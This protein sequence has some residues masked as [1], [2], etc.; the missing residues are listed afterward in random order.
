MHMFSAIDWRISSYRVYST[1]GNIRRDKWSGRLGGSVSRGFGSGGGGGFDMVLSQWY[2]QKRH[3]IRY[4][5]SD[6]LIENEM[7]KW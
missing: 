2:F 3:S 1:S 6:G 5:V 4:K 7:V